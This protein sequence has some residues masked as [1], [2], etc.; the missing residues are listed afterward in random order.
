MNKK[1]IPPTLW[2]KYETDAR[3]EVDGV[4]VEFEGYVV[5]YL[6]RAGGANR[7]YRYALGNAARAFSHLYTAEVRDEQAIYSAGEEIQM[8][9]FAE[10]VIVG[11]SSSMVDRKGAELPFSPAAALDLIRSCPAIWDHLKG[12]AI[13]D[14][15]FK[16]EADG[17]QL[18]KSLSGG[19]RGAVASTA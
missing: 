15:L 11:W 13:S 8:M 1:T 10:A 19:E 18:G 7:A 14:A 2:D 9:A 12:Q 16:P 4:P 3:K 5:F 17:E 6:R